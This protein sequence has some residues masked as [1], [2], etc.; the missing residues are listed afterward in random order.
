MCGPHGS[1]QAGVWDH[2]DVF[3]VRAVLD[4]RAGKDVAETVDVLGAGRGEE[5]GVV[6]FDADDDGDFGLFVVS[7]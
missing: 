1:L 6:A 3:S 5:A 7:W 4:D 2:E